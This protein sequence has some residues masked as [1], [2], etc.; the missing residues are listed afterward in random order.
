MAP[1]PKRARPGAR[2]RPPKPLA[3]DEEQSVEQPAVISDAPVSSAGEEEAEADVATAIAPGGEASPTEET[4]R[5]HQPPGPLWSA[6]LV[7]V[8]TLAGRDVSAVLV[9][10]VAYAAGVALVVT[11]SVLGYLAQ[12]NTGQPATMAPVLAWLAVAMAVL[13]PLVTARSLARE[14]R[15]GTLDLMFSSPLRTWEIVVGKW[16]G[17]FALYL[18]AVALTLAYAVLLARY[19][20]GGVDAGA[21]AAGYAGAVLVGAAWVAVGLLVS[22][23]ASGPFVAAVAGAGVLLTLEVVLG[24]AAGRAGPPVSDLLDYVSAASRA[25][26]FGQGEVALRDVVYF[27]SLTAGALVAATCATHL[28]RRG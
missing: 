1:P 8:A 25:Q 4:V 22:S 27:V 15:S 28:R 12:V 21:V 19:Q 16:L 24:W 6:G 17:G 5:R 10:P 20:P 14:R 26:A 23:V 9:S 7:S 11:V 18:L 13:T 2:K 3:G